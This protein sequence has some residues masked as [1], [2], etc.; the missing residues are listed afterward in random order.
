MTKTRGI[1]QSFEPTQV[2]GIDTRVWQDKGSSTDNRGV[3]FTLRGEVATSDGI[4]PLLR[5]W[6]DREGNLN[7][8]F[9][10]QITAIGTFSRDGRTDILVESGG[11]ILLVDGTET[12]TLLSGRH[13]P[14]NLDE[15][16]R[17]FQVGSNLLITNGRDP[18]LK[19]DGE[20]ITP[21]GVARPPNP[22]QLVGAS[23]GDSDISSAVAGAGS[24]F[25]GGYSIT[26]TA[27]HY[28]YRYKMSWM[29]EFGQ[30]SELSPASNVMEDADVTTNY[31][32]MILV[33]GLEGTPPQDDIIGRWL[34]RSVDQIGYYR[35]RYLPGTDGDH[36][37]DYTDPVA[38]LAEIAKDTGWNLPPPLSKFC[39]LFRGKTYYGGNEENPNVIFYSEGDGAKEAVPVDNFILL[40]SNVADPITGYSI[41]GDFA[42][43]FKSRSTYILTQ[44]KTGLPIV[45]PLSTTIGAVSDKAAI[46]FEGRVYFVS[47]SGLFAFDGSKIVPLSPD[48]A[49][50]IKSVPR[51]S[52]RNSFAWSDPLE[53][54]VYFSIA[55]GPRSSNN[56][57]W[58]IHVDSGALSKIS[59]MVTAACFHK[60]DVLVGYNSSIDGTGVDDLG[61]WGCGTRL[62]YRIP[63][64]S[65][66]SSVALERR[67]ETRWMF[68]KSPQS[69]KTF[70]R[71]D[72]FYM[73]TGGYQEAAPSQSL[74]GFDNRIYVEWF[75]DWDRNVV[76]GTTI[77]PADPGALLWNDQVGDGL[78]AASWGQRESG[79][80]R[81]LWDEK[82]VRSKRINIAVTD[83]V[84][85]SSP[86]PLIN[87]ASD[88]SGENITAKSIKFSFSTGGDAGWR[89]IGFMLHAEDHGI[90][91]EGTDHE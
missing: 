50:V 77:T 31:R 48:I 91:A 65:D 9:H 83:R 76:G 6:K 18:N 49:S 4:R 15:S 27:I 13:I 43:L 82:R 70:Y 56:E 45:T 64:E 40:G 12:R 2:A 47:E 29:S 63:S 80:T 36:Y 24:L 78:G 20:K 84:D 39:F 41:A 35:L 66:L 16:T 75:T 26:K 90:R 21:L 17:F 71:L 30:E 58:A 59:V 67:F 72:V 88:P 79:P 10:G 3:F 81:R 62:Y 73:Q 14:S 7:N 1:I 38:P 22:P 46:G 53:R 34:Y 69:D 5:L 57:V 60:G 74:T 11:A 52:L 55:V 28:K 32:Y 8:P 87:E 37:I 44:D 85:P 51:G 89:I 25:W 54:R 86:L 19:W 68:L 61:V 33:A 42:L 23:D